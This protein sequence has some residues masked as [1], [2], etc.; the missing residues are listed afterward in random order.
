[1]ARFALAA[2]TLATIGL[3]LLQAPAAS[4]DDYDGEADSWDSVFGDSEPPFYI[5]GYAGLSYYD[6]DFNEGALLNSRVNLG[7]RP[8]R[9]PGR[10]ALGFGL[11]IDAVADEDD[12]YTAFYPAL[13]IGTDFGRFQL[14]IPRSVVDQGY[15]PRSNFA[16]SDFLDVQLREL[17]GSYMS[18]FYLFGDETP[19]GVRY[20]NRVGNFKFGASWHRTDAGGVDLDSTS[21]AL[22]YR[23]PASGGGP[24][25]KFAAA[26]EHLSDD[27]SDATIWRLGGQARWEDF[28]LGGKYTDFDGN[29][30]LTELYLDYDFTDRFSVNL[31]GLSLDSFGTQQLYG[32]GLKY[33]VIEN[34]SL[35]GSYIRDDNGDDLVEVGT[36][37]RF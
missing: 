3:T 12:S 30:S 21:A 29:Q 11:G 28:K 17:T 31:S 24:A 8:E 25:L 14:G 13:K 37:V 9:E 34:F 16:Y 20:D 6:T 10:I 18:N 36:R 7:W 22:G 26:V 32:L 35:H 27:I 2:A 1:M 15:L 33:R 19:A 23:L 5:R 4:A